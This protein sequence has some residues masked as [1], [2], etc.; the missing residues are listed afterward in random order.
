MSLVAE[1]SETEDES[2]S[3]SSVY[4]TSPSSTMSPPP[5]PG[6]A[7]RPVVSLLNRL[8]SPEPSK[9][10]RKRKAASNAPNR[11]K[12]RSTGSTS[13]EPK[14]VQP[15]QRVRQFSSEPLSVRK[16]KLFCEACREELSLK[17]SVLH[18]HMKSTKHNEG[19]KSLENKVA[20]EKSI[21]EA[22]RKHNQVN[23]LVG[24]T[25]PD[26]QQVYRVKVVTSF[27]RAAVPLNKIIHFRELL[28]DH[29]YRLTDRRHL[30]D[31]I[32]FIRGEEQ[33]KIRKMISNK[34]ISVI[35]D[36][37]TRLGEVLAIVIRYVSDEW[38]LEQCL[39]KVQL[40]AKSL[41]GEEIAR[42]LIS[43]LSVHYS[44]D[45]S[46]LLACMRD[47]AASNS[48]AVRTLKIVY[49]NLLDIGCFSHALDR[50]GE[51]FNL[52]ILSDFISLWLA[53]FSHSFKARLIW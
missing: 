30:S 43:V 53:M 39:V 45:S 44:V 28:E 38:S 29:A 19:K 52:P 6:I 2:D 37:T 48:V 21:A 8:K 40:L 17:T 16:N 3:A 26:H 46:Q 35:F 27:L 41:S 50:V 9:L 11:Q 7:A 51:Y 24:E 25:L 18:N 20:R 36:G 14:T 4:P 12:R 32:P 42:E 13:S 15:L 1:Y 34:Q 10:C 5:D 49:P 31:L 47:R 23:H 22:L 33:S